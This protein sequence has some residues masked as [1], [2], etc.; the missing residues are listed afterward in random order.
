MP[1]NGGCWPSTHPTQE[2]EDRLSS[3][4][5]RENDVTNLPDTKPSAELTAQDVQALSSLSDLQLEAYITAAQGTEAS[6]I[7]GYLAMAVVHRDKRWRG[8][9]ESFG[10]YLEHVGMARATAYRW[11]DAGVSL[12]AQFGRTG[13]P[14]VKEAKARS[15]LPVGLLGG[16]AGGVKESGKVPGQGRLA[17]TFCPPSK[18]PLTTWTNHPFHVPGHPPYRPSRPTCGSCWRSSPIPSRLTWL[19][20]CRTRTAGPSCAGPSSS[21]S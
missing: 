6:T 10:A 17:E 13:A 7:R 11:R 9:Y 12:I 18:Q 19:P 15:A 20:G 14:N 16:R 5:E 4:D 21:R 3:T 2:E 8:R 1:G